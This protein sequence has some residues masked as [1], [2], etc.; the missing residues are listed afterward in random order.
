MRQIT[1]QFILWYG[2]FETFVFTGNIFGWTALHYMLRQEGIYEHVCDTQGNDTHTYAN[3]TESS[4]VNL[5]GY[6]TCEAQDS[7]LNLAYT[8]GSFCMGSTSFVWGFLLDKWGLR[9]VRLIINGLITSGCILLSLTIR[10]T[11]FLL[12]SFINPVMYRWSPFTSG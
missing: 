8:I 4:A 1:R 9:N 2:L 6:R 5:R 11:S 3:E 10:E 7:I 12:F